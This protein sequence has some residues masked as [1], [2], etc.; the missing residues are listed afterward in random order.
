MKLTDL[1][2][3]VLIVDDSYDTVDLIADMIS[4]NTKLTA[5]KSFSAKEGL[6]KLRE[7]E[8][9]LVLLDFMMPEKTGLEMFPE[10]KAINPDLPVIFITGFGEDNL[11][12]QALKL[13][14]FDF[15]AK[16]ARSKDLMILLSEAL[17]LINRVKQIRT[18]SN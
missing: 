11:K 16:P 15:L 13:G 10:I 9:D 6:A 17:A 4:N 14:A 18:A 1:R 8:I 5:I 12:E 2:G 3:R 7:Q